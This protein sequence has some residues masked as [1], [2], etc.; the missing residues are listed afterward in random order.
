ME[1]WKRKRLGET[2]ERRVEELERD[3]ARVMEQS[4]SMIKARME[5]QDKILPSLATNINGHPDADSPTLVGDDDGP[6]RVV[7]DNA[8]QRKRLE[9]AAWSAA[10]GAIGAG[11]VSVIIHLLSR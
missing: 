5:G 3:H 10:G 4:I 7:A 2:F 6:V 9:T 11:I 1:P 8:E